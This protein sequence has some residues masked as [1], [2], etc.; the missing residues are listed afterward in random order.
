M[1]KRVVRVA[2]MMASKSELVTTTAARGALR[3]LGDRTRLRRQQA[4]RGGAGSGDVG[5]V[6]VYV[7][8]GRCGALHQSNVY[9]FAGG[10]PWIGRKR[11]LVG[12]NICNSE[13]Q[14]VV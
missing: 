9:A 8:V 7:G 10:L 5:W 4:Q 12:P 1:A 13:R 14:R 6:T 3:G 2:V 11:V